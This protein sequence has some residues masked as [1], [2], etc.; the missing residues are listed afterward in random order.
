M[1]AAAYEYLRPTPPFKRWKLPHADEVAFS[2]IKHARNAADH[3]IDRKQHS[4]RVAHNNIHDTNSLI[5]VIAHEMIH[6]Y[7]DG[8]LKTGSSKVHHNKEFVRLATRVCKIHGWNLRF[9]I[10]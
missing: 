10:D 4:I 2:V 1:F 6:A 7:Q 3:C 9:F 8:V 5:E